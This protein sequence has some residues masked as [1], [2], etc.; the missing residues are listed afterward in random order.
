MYAT[1]LGLGDDTWEERCLYLSEDRG[2]KKDW[3]PGGRV[4]GSCVLAFVSQV[5]VVISIYSEYFQARHDHPPIPVILALGEERQE[6][7]VF[8]SILGY[9]GSL[10]SM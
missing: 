4:E 10:N 3:G 5:A 2:D 6:N 8:N 1:T 7:Q 9:I